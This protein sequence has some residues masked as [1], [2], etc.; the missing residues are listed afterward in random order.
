MVFPNTYSRLLHLIRDQYADIVQFKLIREGEE[1]RPS[2]EE[3][4]EY[5]GSIREYIRNKVVRVSP[6]NKWFKTEFL[7]SH[8]IG[9]PPYSYSEDTAFIWDVFQ[10]DGIMLVTNLQGY[11]YLVGQNSIERSREVEMMKQTIED[12]LATNIHLKDVASCYRDCPAVKGN[13]THKYRVLFSR[14]LFA[15]YSYKELKAVFLQCAKIGISHLHKSK[16]LW[17]ID[18]LY[19][20]PLLFFVCRPF[21]CH[22]YSRRHAFAQ[23]SPDFICK[24]L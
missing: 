13:F 4:V 5:T 11:H 15:P 17:V 21:I 6:C 12:L 8:N 9:F 24:R 22:L 14:I 7:T 23:G 3:C 16:N 19:H 10:Y 18:F 2:Q 20:N 1:L